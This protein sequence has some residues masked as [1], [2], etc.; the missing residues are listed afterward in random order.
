MNGNVACVP[1]LDQRGPKQ[2]IQIAAGTGITNSASP[3]T[4]CSQ[5]AC[6]FPS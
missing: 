4:A 1:S 2:R 6:S 3:G 5:V